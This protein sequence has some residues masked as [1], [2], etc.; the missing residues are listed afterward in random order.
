MLLTTLSQERLEA[1][2]AAGAIGCPGCL[3][4]LLRW[5]FARSREV[6]MLHGVRSLRSRRACCEACGVTHV[7]TP[8]WS[9]PLHQKPQRAAAVVGAVDAPTAAAT[10][11]LDAGTEREVTRRGVAGDSDARDARL[12]APEAHTARRRGGGGEGSGRLAAVALPGLADRAR[13]RGTRRRADR[14]V[15]PRAERTSSSRTAAASAPPAL[16]ESRGSA[17]R[18]R[19]RRGSS[20]TARSAAHGRQQRSAAPTRS[21]GKRLLGGGRSEVRL[22][23]GVADV[24]VDVE[25]VLTGSRP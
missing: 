12:P 10:E 9:V 15:A 22:S 6:R 14:R 25:V 18:R 2:L 4:R 8:S 17:R 5:G 11:L 21:V 20:A 23:L 13:A 24:V 3:G 16:R 7:L 19:A 1:D